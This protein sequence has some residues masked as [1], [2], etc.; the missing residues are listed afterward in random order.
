MNTNDETTFRSYLS[1][2]GTLSEKVISDNISRCKRVCR[3]YGDLS[4]FNENRINNIRDDE[5]LPQRLQ[6]SGNINRGLASI[7]RALQLYLNYRI[8]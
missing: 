8:M 4:D 3:A 1:S 2:L 5:N 6:M 7:R